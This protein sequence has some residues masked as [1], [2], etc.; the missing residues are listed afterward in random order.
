MQLGTSTARTARAAGVSLHA[1]TCGL[2]TGYA[3]SSLIRQNS[4]RYT[5]QADESA[6]AG[7]S[8]QAY[9]AEDYHDPAH[10]QMLTARLAKTKKRM[11][12]RVRPDYSSGTMPYFHAHAFLQGQDF[13]DKLTIQVKAGKL[14]LKEVRYISLC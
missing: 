3:S 2:K 4:R 5:S 6:S 10:A 9:N 14:Q 13:V 1:C 8:S 7:P 12:K 11:V